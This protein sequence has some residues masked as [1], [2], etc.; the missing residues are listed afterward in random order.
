ML[1]YAGQNKH[2]TFSLPPVSCQLAKKICLMRIVFTLVQTIFVSSNSFKLQNSD[3]THETLNNSQPVKNTRIIGLN[4]AVFLQPRTDSN[5]LSGCLN[6]ELKKQI[7]L[8]Y[9]IIVGMPEPNT[10]GQ[11]N[12]I[13]RC[14]LVFH[15]I[16]EWG[17]AGYE[18]LSKTVAGS[19]RP[20]P[21]YCL[22]PGPGRWAWWWTLCHAAH[23]IF[24]LLYASYTT[25]CVQS[26]SCVMVLLAKE[27]W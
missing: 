4:S 15:V 17:W 13:S 5:A 3:V 8:R 27:V 1:S 19:C 18:W 10:G 16:I 24:L 2:W 7:L 11:Q 9:Q 14:S 25:C 20:G 6:S 26:V 23:S 21:G 12:L 22:Q